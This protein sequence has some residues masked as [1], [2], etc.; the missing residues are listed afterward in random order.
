MPERKASDS[1]AEGNRRRKASAMHS[2]SFIAVA[3]RAGG[4][5]AEA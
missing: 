3:L 2:I 5:F 1:L 4:R